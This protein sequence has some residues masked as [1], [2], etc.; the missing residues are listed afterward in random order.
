MMVRRAGDGDEPALARLRWVWRVEERD[1]EGMD[2]SQFLDALTAWIH[3]HRES[4]LAW[5][6]ER[7]GEACGMAWLAVTHRVPGPGTWTRLAGAIQSVYV[8][9]E[10]RNDGI[11]AALVQAA[12]GEAGRL[13]LDYLEVHPSERSFP[14]YRR[15]GFSDTGRVLRLD[16][17]SRE[18]AR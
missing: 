16:L 18:Y 7:D 6:A 11:G 1:E 10:Y 4:H 9:P 14:L 13:G 8:R 15:T 5:L 2:W 3:D 17:N 12:I